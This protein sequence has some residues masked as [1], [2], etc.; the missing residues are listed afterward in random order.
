MKSNI[1]NNPCFI[2]NN[3]SPTSLGQPS[4]VAQTEYKRLR[5]W[6]NAVACY[7][8]CRASPKPYTAAWAWRTPPNK[9]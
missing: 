4:S 2:H 7:W 6:A 9:V 5:G 1:N 8:A 3:E